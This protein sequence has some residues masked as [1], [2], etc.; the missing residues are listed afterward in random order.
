MATLTCHDEGLGL[1]A[2]HRN[3]SRKA[4]DLQHCRAV[5]VVFWGHESW[6]GPPLFFFFFFFFF[7]FRFGGYESVFF[8]GG[9][10]F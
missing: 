4:R 7:F 2:R 1:E 5:P 10:G 8:F 9:V 6:R 3:R